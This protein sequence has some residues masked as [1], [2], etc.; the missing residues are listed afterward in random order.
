M[1]RGVGL[2]VSD[3]GAALD[4]QHMSLWVGEGGV[5]VVIEMLPHQPITVPVAQGDAVSLLWTRQQ[6][7]L[8][9]G[10]EEG[11]FT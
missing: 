6:A 7:V 3:V 1:V 11:I 2:G 10:F 8:S 5:G 4:A 9:C